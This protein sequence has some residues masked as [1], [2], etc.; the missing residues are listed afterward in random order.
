VF[1][2]L[3]QL[4]DEKIADPAAV[5]LGARVALRW[6]DP[7]AAMMDRLGGDA[8]A[9]LLQPVLERYRVAAPA[10]LGRVGALLARPS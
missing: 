5:D 4:V 10:S 1:L 3:L 7:P 6:D 9:K 2:P 8:V